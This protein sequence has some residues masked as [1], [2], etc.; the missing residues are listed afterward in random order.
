[1]IFLNAEIAPMGESSMLVV[2]SI[3]IIANRAARLPSGVPRRH[4]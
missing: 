1:L 2:I 3:G 4:G